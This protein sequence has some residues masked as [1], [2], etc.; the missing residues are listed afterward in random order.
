M[1][2]LANARASLRVAARSVIPFHFNHHTNTLVGAWQCHA[3][4]RNLFICIRVFVNWCENR[5]FKA[6]QEQER[7][8]EVRFQVYLLT[9]QASFYVFI[10]NSQ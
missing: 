3:P 5:G 7:E 10:I 6:S 1:L 8:M 2:A 9:F 4:T